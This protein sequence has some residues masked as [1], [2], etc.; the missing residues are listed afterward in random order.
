MRFSRRDFLRSSAAL[1][2]TGLLLDRPS[3]AAPTWTHRVVRARHPLASCFDIVDFEYHKDIRDTYYGNFVSQDAVYGMFDRALC[4]LTGDTDPVAAM[5]RLVPYNPG[6]RVFM[7]INTTTTYLMW[8]GEWNKIGWDPHYNDTDSIAEP[9][10]ATI[11]ALTRIGVPQDKIALTDPS[12]SEGD[13]D[14]MQRTPRLVPD[15]LAK[16]IKAAFPNVE[17]YRSSSIPDGNGITWTS[18]D[19]NAMVKFRDP[20]IDGR[21]Q[22]ALSHRVP[23]QLIQADHFLSIPIMKRHDQGG[24]TGAFKNNFGTIASCAYFHEPRYNGPGKP[25]AMFS[26]SANP[27]VDI[28]LNRHVG[29]KMRLVVCDGI[30]GGWNWGMDPP[31]GWRQFNGRSPN[32]LL[33]ATDPV[34]IDSVIYDHVTESLPDK[35]KGYAG[36]NML[37]DA[38]QLGLGVHESRPAPNADYK[39]IDYVELNETVDGAKLRQLAELRNK[40]KAGEKSAALVKDLLAEAR[41]IIS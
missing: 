28:W 38:A 35:V 11:R 16:K 32:C 15:R 20:L 27:A 9:I 14:P 33:L 41:A 37:V 4:A 34:A 3:L 2:A 25:G 12:W 8:N 31:T 10:N 22:G 21:K 26:D 23:D 7:K 18:N 5:R 13:P 30:F 29:A 24:V 17:I 36:P 40:Y 1:A 39:N 19:A 6:E